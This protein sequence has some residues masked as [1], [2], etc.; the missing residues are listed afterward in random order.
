MSKKRTIA[1]I[2]AQAAR[3]AECQAAR[4]GWV[5]QTAAVWRKAQR[6]MDDRCGEAV[7]RLDEAAFERLFAAEQAKVAAIM[8]KLRAVADQDKWPRGLYF[9]GI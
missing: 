6:Q 3:P 8:A 1:E 7:E 2:F 9:S 5:K 4:H